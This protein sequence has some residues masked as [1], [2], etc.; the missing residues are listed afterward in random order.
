VIATYAA[1]GIRVQPLAGFYGRMPSASEARNLA[2]WA[3]AY[4]PGGTYWNSHG[5][6]PEPIEAIEFGN[7][8]SYTYQ[9]GD[10]QTSPSYRERGERY[11]ER[12]KEAAEAISAAGSSVGL[13]AQADDWTGNWVGAIFKAVPGFARFVAGWTIHPYGPTWKKRIEDLIRQ[14]GEHGAP[15]TIPI[16][17]TEWGLSTDN[18][19]CLSENYGWNRC[20]SYTEAGEVL[21]RTVAEMRQAFASR[22]QDFI[23]YQ[24]HDLSAS[25]S[26][27]DREQYFGALQLGHQ[28]KGTF[29]GAVESM[30]AS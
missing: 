11:G 15:A 14:T 3:Q 24:V 23:L 16:D 6:T 13:L 21:K 7:E 25:G 27:G 12:F 2:S 8:T 9:Y 5:G 10:S 26:S 17:V 20:M 28:A 18:G 1:K 30:L 29:T 19:R 22:L 4:G